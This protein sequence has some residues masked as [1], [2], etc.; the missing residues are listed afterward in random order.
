MSFDGEDL[1]AKFFY[2]SGEEENKSEHKVGRVDQIHLHTLRQVI[3]RLVYKLP[4][5]LQNEV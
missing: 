1:E 4:E 2:P 5:L 3:Y